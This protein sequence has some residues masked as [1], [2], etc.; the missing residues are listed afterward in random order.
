M[1]LEYRSTRFISQIN[2]EKKKLQPTKTKILTTLLIIT[3]LTTLTTSLLLSQN[4]AAHSPPWAIPTYA[5]LAVS[6][7]PIG[8]GQSVNIVMWAGLVLPGA[9]VGNEVRFRDYKL[10][11]IHPDGHNEIQT[12]PIIIDTTST[13]FTQ[14]TPK[15][16]G[17]Y[18]FVFS[19]PDLNYTWSASA[20]YRNDLFLGATSKTITLIV[21][22][23]PLPN[24]ITSYPLPTEYWTRPIE[25][26]NTDWWAITS[27]WLGEAHPSI[28]NNIRVQPDG[29]APNSAHIIW[30]KPIDE[31]GIVGGTNTGVEGNMYFSGLA[32]QARF[33]NP[34]IMNGKLF[35]GLPL[36]NT[37]TGGGYKAI[38]LQT[39]QDLWYSDKI[40]VSGSAA[41]TFGY[42]YDFN[43]ENQHGVIPPGMLF[44]NNFASG[45]DPL[46]G[47]LRI[48]ITGVPTGIAA[49]GPHGE[50]LRY[51][52]NIPNR[53][54]AQWNSSKVI[55]AVS[56]TAVAQPPT[57]AANLPIC[58]DWNITLPQAIPTG[59]SAQFAIY[60]DILVGSTTLASFSGFQTPDPYTMWAISLKPETRG[61]LLWIQNYTAP[62]GV[63]RRLPTV[64]PI[65][66]VIVF[67]DKETMVFQGYSLDTGKHLWTTTPIE[68]VSDYEY[69][70]STFA[71]QLFMIANG[72]LH[73]AGMGGVVYGYDTKD[74]SLLWTNGND[75]SN[76]KNSTF[77]GFQ[78]AYGHY[79]QFITLVADG[80]VFVESGDH[81]PDSPLWKGAKL[82]VLNATNG[83]EIWS[84]M[85]YGGFP[86]RTYAAVADG[87]YVFN[88]CYNHQLTAFGKGPSALTVEAPMTST[89]LGNSLV[90]RGSVMDI[91]AGTQQTE[92][93]VRFPQGVPVVSDE[94][95]AT[96]MEYIYMQK[97]RPTNT[98]GVPVTLSVIDANDNY[99]EIGK[100]TTQ[101]GFFSFN[102]KPD[103]EG[104][105]TIYATFE[106]SE[107]YWPSHAISSFV[108][109]PAPTTP[110]PQPTTA[111]PPLETYLTAGVAAIIITIILVA[112]VL[113]MAIKKRP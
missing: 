55:W 89:V 106:G 15:E 110:T 52:L 76:P 66:R 35:Y 51:Q 88:N 26:Q 41:P 33:A 100:A 86:G 50:I 21:Q 101:D 3:L 13:Q 69:F 11:I 37:P 70:D 81:S 91:S 74:G 67:R 92:Q 63:T 24:A 102:W 107:S 112:V 96:W 38:N 46:T 57:A 58:Y 104:P 7:N 42:L 20:T 87:I 105:Y 34:I 53:W 2:L 17:N 93:V 44:T 71:A 23:E 54:I 68:N 40:G 78:T 60:N 32:Y 10:T 14:Y 12:W 49:T 95:Q 25:G 64:D 48:N 29:T 27:N 43:S 16:I 82:R 31:G 19:Y 85:G 62:E 75:P 79:P 39:G 80:K 77:S 28:A 6:P 36:Q 90:I 98:I 84:I 47:Q 83:E 45:Y 5:F 109:D 22:E 56:G 59:T 99:R 4:T 94:S 9:T 61:T 65:N 113:L 111:L 30:T 8:V 18:T 73:H 1:S 97:P 108:V 72:C 103:I